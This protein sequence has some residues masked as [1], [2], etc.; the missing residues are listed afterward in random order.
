MF[1]SESLMNTFCFCR[2]L[3]SSV[4]NHVTELS[5]MS[6]DVI[7]IEVLLSFLANKY[8]KNCKR[9]KDSVGHQVWFDRTPVIVDNWGET[10]N[11]CLWQVLIYLFSMLLKIQRPEMRL[12]EK[13][14]QKSK[15]F[16]V[17]SGLKPRNIRSAK[18]KNSPSWGKNG[19]LSR[20]PLHVWPEK[21]GSIVGRI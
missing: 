13:Q 14:S 20:R 19:D 11:S 12:S 17:W 5:E 9:K 15:R 2:Y 21:G 16:R 18:K 10:S 1:S 6:C 7:Q 8:G 3:Q 4:P